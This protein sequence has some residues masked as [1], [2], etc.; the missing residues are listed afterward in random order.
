[1]DFPHIILLFIIYSFIVNTIS[2]MLLLMQT[3]STGHTKKV[4]PRKIW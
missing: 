1:L 2:Y 3:P 4:T